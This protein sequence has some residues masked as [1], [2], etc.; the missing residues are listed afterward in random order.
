MTKI[1][2]EDK[3]ISINDNVDV[4]KMNYNNIIAFYEKAMSIFCKIENKLVKKLFAT[5]G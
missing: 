1:R 4:Y 2:S 5:S 3:K